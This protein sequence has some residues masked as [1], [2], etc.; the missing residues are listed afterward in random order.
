MNYTFSII[1]PH[2]NIP[3]LLQR[4]L[5][6]IPIREDLEVIVVDDNSDPAIVDFECFPGKNRQN[7]TI[8]FDKS[9]KG[10]GH[11]RNVGLK[12]ASGEKILFAD[13]DD[14]FT[15]NIGS[16]LDE[17]ASSNEDVVFFRKISVMSD[18]L[19]KESQRSKWNEEI[20]DKYFQT[21]DESDIRCNFG[22]PWAKII[23][24]SL[25][26]EN[27]IHFA[28]IAYSNDIEF[29]AMVGVKAKK[30]KVADQTMYVCTERPGSLTSSLY[31]KE[32]ELEIRANAC[33]SYAK[34]IT[35]H[36][37]PFPVL[38]I[39]E[40]LNMM[41]RNDMSLYHRFSMRLL[42]SRLDYWK[43]VRQAGKFMKYRK[44]PFYVCSLFIIA[45]YK[46]K[47]AVQCIC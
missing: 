11:A 33:L 47:K 28:E 38:P 37:Y 32:G 12:L 21:G 31:S 22:A 26:I 18:D 15:S 29:S 5:D 16:I 42:G 44:I 4:C 23:K 41:F 9:S 3:K 25:I 10:A 17:Y 1:I 8:I 40:F 27:D 36:G 39:A 7:T 45:C 13:A 43:A 6:S 34:I 24:R 20:I 46:V 35:E 19:S 14:F 30:I 2:K